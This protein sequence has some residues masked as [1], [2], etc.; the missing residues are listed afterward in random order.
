[1]RRPQH[2]RIDRQGGSNPLRNAVHK[3]ADDKVLCVDGIAVQQDDW[4]ACTALKVMKSRTVDGVH[5]RG[6]RHSDNSAVT[7]NEGRESTLTGGSWIAICG[8]PRMA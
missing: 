4:R 6:R 5:E 2:V 7:G 1:M 3:A 8:N